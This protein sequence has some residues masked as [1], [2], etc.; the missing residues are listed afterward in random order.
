MP[1]RFTRHEVILVPY[2]SNVSFFLSCLENPLGTVIAFM[3]IAGIWILSSGKLFPAPEPVYTKFPQA[4]KLL[5]Q[6]RESLRTNRNDLAIDYCTRAIKVDP[7]FSEAYSTRGIA[8]SYFTQPN[9]R[10]K[11]YEKALSLFQAQGYYRE[12][13]D[14]KKVIHAHKYFVN[15]RKENAASK[16]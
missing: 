16:N 13:E 15:L 11:N 6:C 3:L 7:N 1:R 2:N 14:M 8:Y 12:A 5:N 9:E 10:L 4:Q